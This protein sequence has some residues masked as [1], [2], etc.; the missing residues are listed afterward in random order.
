MASTIAIKTLLSAGKRKSFKKAH[1]MTSK[2]NYHSYLLRIWRPDPQTPWRILIENI[3]ARER[4]GIRDWQE[5][6]SFLRTDLTDTGGNE[7][8]ALTAAE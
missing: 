3:P 1:L 6:L 7:S 4:K 5:L 8:T 2:P